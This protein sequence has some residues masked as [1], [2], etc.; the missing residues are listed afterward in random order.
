[1]RFPPSSCRFVLFHHPR[2]LQYSREKPW[3]VDGGVK[4]SFVIQARKAAKISLIGEDL[5][6]CK[7]IKI[8]GA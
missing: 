6:T 1:M 3:S 8:V 4:L 7:A 2:S 5:V